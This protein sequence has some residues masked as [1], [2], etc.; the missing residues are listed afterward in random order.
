VWVVSC[1]GFTFRLASRWR[2]S[3]EN[4]PYCNGN[5]KWFWFFDDFM[6]MLAEGTAGC[7]WRDAKHCARDARGP[8]KGRQSNKKNGQSGGFALAFGT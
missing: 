4:V 1:W 3:V 8:R 5:C 7:V 2:S 6:W